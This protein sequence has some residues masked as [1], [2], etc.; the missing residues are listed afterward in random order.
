[1]RECC[2]LCHWETGK[3]DSA[4]ISEPGDMHKTV[5]YPNGELD[6]NQNLIRQTEACRKSLYQC[7]LLICICR[8]ELP[9]RF[10]PGLFFAE[11]YTLDA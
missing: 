3:A 5:I 6:R 1:M 10:L 7:A 4:E 9:Q 11:S 8:G 2:L